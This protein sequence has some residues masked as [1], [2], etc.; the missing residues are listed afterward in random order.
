MYFCLFINKRIH[1][2]TTYRLFRRPPIL[3]VI[4]MMRLCVWVCGFVGVRICV[5]VRCVWVC[6]FVRVWSL[7]AKDTSVYFFV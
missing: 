7:H 5:L 2:W 1:L 4:V 3:V 6:G